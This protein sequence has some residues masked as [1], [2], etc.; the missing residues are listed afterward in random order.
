MDIWITKVRGRP[1]TCAYCGLTIN[2]GDYI[3]RGKLWKKFNQEGTSTPRR[4]CIKLRWHVEC[5]VEQGKYEADRAANNRVE[6]RGRPSLAM[7]E[8]QKILRRKVIA[9][10]A[11]VLQRIQRILS[12]PGGID[13]VDKLAHLGDMLNS[14]NVEIEL[15]GGR[16]K[17]WG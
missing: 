3:V 5:W 2:T 15:L 16:P 14:L 1:A 12:K 6:C 4:W 13:E 9:R 17:S 11:S 8:E 10:R 7:T